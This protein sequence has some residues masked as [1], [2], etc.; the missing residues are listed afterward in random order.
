MTFVTHT[1]DSEGTRSLG[2]K[3]SFLLRGGDVIELVSDLGGGKTTLTQGIAHG[4]GYEDL[5]TSPTFTL[6][7]VY[8]LKSGLEIHHYDLYRLS[9]GGV[10]DFEIG[11]DIAAP[12]VI[13]IVEWGDV[14]QD[15]LPSDRLQIVLTMDTESSRE[16]KISGSGVR[17]KT[18]IEGLNQ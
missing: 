14:V 13:T 17:S 16:I 10:L 8:P 6:S 5:V 11:E 9:E 18:I 4:L 2:A 12:N 15:I 3:L 7:Q 1:T